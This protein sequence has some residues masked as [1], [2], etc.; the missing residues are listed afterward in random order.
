MK[1]PMYPFV[2]CIYDHKWHRYRRGAKRCP[3]CGGIIGPEHGHP[4]TLRRA[5]AAA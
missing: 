5:E 1:S 4:Q 3:Q 2:L